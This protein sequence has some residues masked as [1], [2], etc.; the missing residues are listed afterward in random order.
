[1]RLLLLFPRAYSLQT[2]SG[3]EKVAVDAFYTA[4]NDPETSTVVCVVDATRLEKGLLFALQ[5]INAC[6]KHQKPLVIAANMVDVLEQ[7]SLNLDIAGLENPTSEN[8]SRWI[9]QQLKPCL[10]ILS[11]LEVKETCTSGCIYRGE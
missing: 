5:V 10:P 1:M 9:W 11:K 6:A 7:H 8:I 3:E 2:I 4:L